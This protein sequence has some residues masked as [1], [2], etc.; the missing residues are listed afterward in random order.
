MDTLTLKQPRKMGQPDPQY[1][2]SYWSYTEESQVPV[3]FNLTSGDVAD[4]QKITFEERVIKQGKKG[5]YHRLKKVRPVGGQQPQPQVKQFKADP[6]KQASIRAQWAIGQAV[7]VH[8]DDLG[9]VES[10]AK[11]LYDMVEKVKQ[12]RQETKTDSKETFT[13]GSPVPEQ[14]DEIVDEEEPINLDDIPF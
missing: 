1:G 10:L 13:D 12:P 5:D 2:Q 6:E 14:P 3:M 11:E 8:A 4:G 7:S 9:K